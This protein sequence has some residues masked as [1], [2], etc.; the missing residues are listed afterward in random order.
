[1]IAR[2]PSQEAVVNPEGSLEAIAAGTC[3]TLGDAPVRHARRQVI[4]N[5]HK[6]PIEPGFL[7]EIVRVGGPSA[8]FGGARG[9]PPARSPIAPSTG[10]CR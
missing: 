1:M 9:P 3:P 7:Q 2:I 10:P 8:A 5:R 4:I 6:R